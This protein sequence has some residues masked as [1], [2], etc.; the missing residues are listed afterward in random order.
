MIHFL[1]NDK[2]FVKISISCCKFL[3][4]DCEA[5]TDDVTDDIT[6]VMVTADGAGPVPAAGSCEG[7]GRG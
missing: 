4:V 6:V 2:T 1:F 7:G 3:Y 5:V